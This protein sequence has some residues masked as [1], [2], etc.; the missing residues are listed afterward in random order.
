MVEYRG[1]F[2]KCVKGCHMLELDFV[3][4]DP[5]RYKEDQHMKVIGRKITASQL[6]RKTYQR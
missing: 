4:C 2:F 3:L 6:N 5:K 1:I